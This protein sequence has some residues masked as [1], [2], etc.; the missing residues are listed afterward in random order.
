MGHHG[1]GAH[2]AARSGAGRPR[3]KT[4]AALAAKKV[5][6]VDLPKEY[7]DPRGNAPRR[8][9]TG[10]GAVHIKHAEH[11]KQPCHAAAIGF[12][13]SAVYVCTD[14]QRHAGEPGSGVERAPD[15]RAQRAQ[16]RAEN[17]RLREASAARKAAAAAWV[18]AATDVTDPDV[19]QFVLTNV[20]VT[21]PH[22]AI[23]PA[24][25]LL[26][27]EPE[28]GWDGEWTALMR[29]AANDPG[30]ALTAV[31]AVQCAAAERDASAKYGRALS[32][33]TVIAYLDLLTR[34]GYQELPGDKAVRERFV[35]AT[36]SIQMDE[37]TGEPGVT[38]GG[39]GAG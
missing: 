24:L 8:L 27:V 22:D 13:G 6:I 7:G 38:G 21:A 10:Y 37:D 2:R 28:T 12:D 18:R 1:G 23:T 16:T 11:R 15:L 3:G 32:G 20:L 29:H 9:G 30:S 26:G 25:A 34:T 14:P 17:K 39:T 33:R 36:R 31:L 4:G 19:L 35:H 5:R